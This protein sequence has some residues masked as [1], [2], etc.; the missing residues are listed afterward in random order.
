MSKVKFSVGFRILNLS[1]K[2]SRIIFVGILIIFNLIYKTI[3]PYFDTLIFST[4]VNTRVPA[5]TISNATCLTSRVSTLSKQTQNYVLKLPKQYLY[6]LFKIKCLNHR[7][8][9]VTGRYTKLPIH[10][11]IFTLC[12]RRDIL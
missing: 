10:Y 6:A 5:H 3:L 1:I 11:C 9:I 4:T 7:F 8:P 12:Q 2:L